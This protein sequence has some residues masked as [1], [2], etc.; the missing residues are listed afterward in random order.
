[1]SANLRINF[2]TY[3]FLIIFVKTNFYKMSIWKKLKAIFGFEVI[4]SKSK[5]RNY[6]VKSDE[7]IEGI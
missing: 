6:S 1:M 4:E 2:C 5:K 3:S 7:E